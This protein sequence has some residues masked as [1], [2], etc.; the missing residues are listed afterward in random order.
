M[1]VHESRHFVIL[2][3]GNRLSTMSA[4]RFA[5]SSRS[6]DLNVDLPGPGGDE[7]CT[8]QRQR[9]KKRSVAAADVATPTEPARLTFRSYVTLTA[10]LA[11]R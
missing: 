11:A 1:H 6:R 5:A 3:L 8:T 4:P 9:R 7:G 2:S 10:E